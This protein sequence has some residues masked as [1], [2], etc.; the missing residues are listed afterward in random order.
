MPTIHSKER[1]EHALLRVHNMSPPASATPAPTQ[2][3]AITAPQATHLLTTF[4]Q[5][6]TVCIHNILFYRGLYPATTFLTSRAYNLPVHQSRHPAVCAWVQDAVDAARAQ[7]AQ[8]SVER[9]AV[10]IYDATGR[11]MER[12]MFD[13]ARFP[14][15]E[16]LSTGDG[17]RGKSKGKGKERAVN[18]EDGEEDS[19]SDKDNDDDESPGGGTGERSEGQQRSPSDVNWTDVDE[20]LRA[21]VRRL[22]YTGEKMAPLPEGCTFTVAVELRDVAEAP[23]GVC[24]VSTTA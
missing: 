20:Q 18:P 9:M 1:K 6:L 15:W 8:G 16:G 14:V 21:A 23:I 22:A 24:T 17:G 13:L 7:I 19:S 4:T 10:V 2:G 3:P 5:F 11:P 12:W